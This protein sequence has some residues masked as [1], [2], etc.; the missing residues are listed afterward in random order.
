MKIFEF[1]LAAGVKNNLLLDHPV[2][3]EVKDTTET[4]TAMLFRKCAARTAVIVEKL[5]EAGFQITNDCVEQFLLP[6]G[7]MQAEVVLE[8]NPSEAVTELMDIFNWFWEGN[9]EKYEAS[10]VPALFQAS[11]GSSNLSSALEQFVKTAGSDSGTDHMDTSEGDGA[12]PDDGQKEE[13]FTTSTPVTAFKPPQKPQPKPRTKAPV[14]VTNPRPPISRTVDLKGFDLHVQTLVVPEKKRKRSDSSSGGESPSAPHPKKK[15]DDEDESPPPVPPS[16][17]S[18]DESKSRK[19]RAGQGDT[20]ADK[21]RAECTK[22]EGNF[23]MLDGTRVHRPNIRKLIFFPLYN[24]ISV[25][26]LFCWV[27]HIS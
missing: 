23:F 2:W 16:R 24:K 5:R 25:V 1:S 27:S 21:A 17:P 3:A 9:K 14:S 4:M 8:Q 20:Y 12:S 7:I 22:G 26:E 11:S 13:E 6:P 15:V 18:K 19:T 10:S